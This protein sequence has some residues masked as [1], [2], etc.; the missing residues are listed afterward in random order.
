[1]IDPTR[2]PE[3]PICDECL[4]EHGVELIKSECRCFR[5]KQ[6][7]YAE[8]VSGYAAYYPGRQRP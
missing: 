1:M 7:T 4:Y 6:L 8:R 3:P 2:E 5:P